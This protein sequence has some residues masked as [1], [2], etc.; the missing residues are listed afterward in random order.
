MSNAVKIDK[1]QKRPDL[2]L[3]IHQQS[4]ANVLWISKRMR[5]EGWW[6]LA[7]VVMGICRYWGGEVF[8]ATAYSVPI[9][10]RA[11]VSH[12]QHNHTAKL[13]SAQL[14]VTNHSLPGCNKNCSNSWWQRSL[15]QAPSHKK[16][17]SFSNSGKTR[18]P[19]LC[20]PQCCC[21]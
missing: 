9:N 19:D 3:M 14:L 12:V 16:P 17:S 10:S 18:S 4:K 11:E 6:L 13:L 20:L 7:K 21:S 1:Q 15:L 2:V 5:S 8:A